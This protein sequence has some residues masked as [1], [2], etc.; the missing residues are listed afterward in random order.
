MDNVATAPPANS[1][2]QAESFDDDEEPANSGRHWRE[3]MIDLLV[4]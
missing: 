2:A 1:P 4:T 3:S